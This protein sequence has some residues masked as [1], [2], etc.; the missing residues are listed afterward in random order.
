MVSRIGFTIMRHADIAIPTAV[1][2]TR[3]FNRRYLVN[4]E[5]LVV[6][7]EL[8]TKE[9]V[10]CLHTRMYSMKKSLVYGTLL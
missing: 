4:N 3:W 5:L 2:Y 8:A 10:A 6:I 1:A 9:L 7:K